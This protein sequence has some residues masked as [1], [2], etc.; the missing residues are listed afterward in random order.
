M[1]AAMDAQSDHWQAETGWIGYYIAGGVGSDGELCAHVYVLCTLL[2][3][4]C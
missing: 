3:A 4:R 2:H 1:P